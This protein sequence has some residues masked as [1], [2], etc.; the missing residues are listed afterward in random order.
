MLWS[1]FPKIF[2]VHRS[3]SFLISLR[4]WNFTNI[5]VDKQETL[6][7]CEH[8]SDITKSCFRKWVWGAGTEM[9]FKVCVPQYR[10]ERWISHQW[11]SIHTGSFRTPKCTHLPLLMLV[12]WKAAL[13][14]SRPASGTTGNPFSRRA[15]ATQTMCARDFMLLLIRTSSQHRTSSSFLKLI[16][17]WNIPF[18][19]ALND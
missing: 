1:N 19:Q 13:P 4:L 9:R 7:S 14:G 15:V 10:S 16:R 8:R 17:L 12:C 18:T 3:V 6:Q 5:N 2:G 11:C